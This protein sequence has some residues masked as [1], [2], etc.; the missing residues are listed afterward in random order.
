MHTTNPHCLPRFLRHPRILAYRFAPPRIAFHLR[1]IAYTIMFGL[2]SGQRIKDR[3]LR[4]PGSLGI[5]CLL[6]FQVIAASAA[7]FG[8]ASYWDRPYAGS[9]SSILYYPDQQAVY[10]RFAWESKADLSLVIRGQL[11]EARYFS[12]NLYNDYTK[13]SIQAL[14]DYQLIPDADNPNTYTIHIRRAGQARRYRNEMILP[15]SVRLASVFLRYYL[16]AVNIFANR[17]LP[18]LQWLDGETLRAVAPSLPMPAMKPED[19]AA[20]RAAIQANPSLLTAAE[21]KTLASASASADQKEPLVCKVLTMPIFAFN[22]DPTQLRAFNFNSAGN[23]PNKDNHYIVMPVTRKQN[24]DIVL[25][26][27]KAPGVASALMDTSHE[28]RYFSLS[29]GSAYTTTAQTLYDQ[30]LRVSEDGFVYVAVGA[31]S[32][33]NRDKAA[34]LGINFMAWHYPERI[35]LILRHMLPA[36]RFLQSARSVPVFQKQRSL[37][38]QGAEKTMGPYALVGKIL[39]KSTW[40]KSTLLSQLAF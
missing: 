12:F 27:F 28:V 36:D 34:Q 29:Q 20:L 16:P 3:L 39:S 11:P 33:E 17:P 30:Q 25:V 6:G 4:K 15:D 13:S 8:Q 21:R 9:D 23:Y 1:Y 10:F 38:E 26:R 35:V 22:P 7:C 32:P 40:K 37:Q 5:A 31:D 14:A 19:A 2:T 24:S 18:Q